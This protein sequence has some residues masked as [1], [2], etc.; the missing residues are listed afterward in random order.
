MAGDR[1]SLPV[2]PLH[3]VMD[4]VGAWTRQRRVCSYDPLVA[5]IIPH[6]VIGVLLPT[7]SEN[8]Q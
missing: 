2:E 8:R 3:R 5:L 1:I 7:A 6:V 4:Q